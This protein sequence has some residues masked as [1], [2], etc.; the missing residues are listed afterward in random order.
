MFFF[1][2]VSSQ[3][4]SF[5]LNASD[6]ENEGLICGRT[7]EVFLE[8][9]MSDPK[10]FILGAGHLGLALAEFGR[11]VGCR[12]TVVDDRDRFAN[13]ERFPPV[14]DVLVRPFE[15]CLRDLPVDRNSY[16]VIVTRG[17][18][19]NCTATEE[20]IQTPARYIGLV[21]SRRKIKLIVETLIGK[22]YSA[23]RFAVGP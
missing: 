9:I 19:H 14:E 11:R 18:S 4:V 3:L 8:P 13:R 17:H 6:A 12:V 5:E 10:L 15:G 21:G 16:V 23:D 20:A 1:F 7:V 2:S 22:G